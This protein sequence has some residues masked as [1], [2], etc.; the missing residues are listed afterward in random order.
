MPAPAGYGRRVAA[1]FL[2]VLASWLLA[3]VVASPWIAGDLIFA[4]TTVN[5]IL[6]VPFVGGAAAVFLLY[7]PIFMRRGGE[8]NGQ[9][10]A[11]QLLG[12]RVVRDDARPVSFGTGVLRDVLFKTVLGFFT[13]GLFNLVDFLWPLWEP[14]RRALHDL[15][16]RTHVVRA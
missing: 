16:A 5:L 11:K 7:E 12:I 4:D 10:V 8:C 6:A 2:D 14:Q 9:T 3:A 13:V 1:F 15:V